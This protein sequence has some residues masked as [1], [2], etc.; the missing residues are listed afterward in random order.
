M[1]Q[2][3]G[4]PV[5]ILKEGTERERNPRKNNIAAI[6]AIS[7]AVRSTLGP[8]GMDKMIV[9]SLGDIIVTNDGATILDKIDVEH[10]AARMI[11]DLAKN[12]DT[13]V[14]D[15]TTSVAIFTG[16]LLGLADE[17]IDSGVHP[18]VVAKGYNAAAKEAV[19]ILD[20][21]AEDVDPDKD[22]EI[23]K[24]AA[25]TTMNSKGIA[26]NKDLFADLAVEAVKYLKFKTVEEAHKKIKIVKK[27]GA[28]L[29][30][31]RI[32][33][34]IVLNKEPVHVMMPKLVNDAKVLVM[35]QSLE[36]KKTTFDTDLR[37]SSADQIQSFLDR[38]E[39][40]F[41]EYVE[42]I[43][44]SGANVVF[45]EKGIEDMAAHFLSKEGILAVKSLSKDDS[46]IL[47]KA[48]GAKLCNSLDD[49]E[50]NMLGKAARIE[51]T[52]MAGDD[53]IFVEGCENPE[54]LSI[55]LRGGTEH[56][57]DEA[58]RT[59]HDAICVVASLILDNRIVGGGGAVELELSK[60]LAKFAT[61][62][63]GK[64]QLAVEA[65]AN[66][67]EIIPKTLV[68]NGGF[69]PIE[70]LVEMRSKHAED[71]G[72]WYGIDLF[73]GQVVD[74]HEASIIEPAV[75]VKYIIEGAIGLANLILRIDDMIRSKKSAGPPGGDMGGMP[76]M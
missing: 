61:Q 41:R 9:D 53:T 40:V 48:T 1:A 28:G 23:L 15:G 71:D 19:K 33:K 47:A 46:K 76:P 57:L 73:Q 67:L 17:L 36:I 38:E 26:G 69:D 44:A 50:P 72:K 66:A 12:Q 65:F 39:N 14:G 42:K 13:Q 20:E 21:I 49:L 34:G 58:E 60:R 62:V 63:K 75:S 2:L 59:I 7:E 74:T 29:H 52:K 68:E 18:S 27:K 16:E 54:S 31:S 43:K 35:A 4:T 10:P 6:K 55:L 8:R 3:A 70:R 56:V 25:K 22:V 5:L 32:V 51:V 37:I 45:N 11:I 30:D 64:Q 24:K